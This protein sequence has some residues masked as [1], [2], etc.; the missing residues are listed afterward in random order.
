[1]STA[2]IKFEFLPLVG[3]ELNKLMPEFKPNGTLKDPE[4][5]KVDL[6]NKKNKWI[7]EAKD[8]VLTSRIVSYGG[9]IYH[10]DEYKE[11]FMFKDTDNNEKFLLSN[12]LNFIKDKAIKQLVWHNAEKS[13]IPRLYLTSQKYGLH[14]H[15]IHIFRNLFASNYDCI[16]NNVQ[17]LSIVE[18]GQYFSIDTSE[19]R[20][21][22][23]ETFF[24]EVDIV[25]KVFEKILI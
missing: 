25:G 7:E 16:K 18:L 10:G 5:I 22:S 1:M 6:E 19:K 12:L 3:A 8:N 11:D 23:D 13:Y 4:K 21:K 2:I 20:N 9:Y 14:N 17:Y 15:L 24:T